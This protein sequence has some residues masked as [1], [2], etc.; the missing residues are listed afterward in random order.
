VRYALLL[1][2]FALP[3]LAQ[4]AATSKEPAETAEQIAGRREQLGDHERARRTITLVIVVAAVL[5]TQRRQSVPYTARGTAV[6][7]KIP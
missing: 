2:F 5:A 3:C 7:G 6:K 1:A 4:D